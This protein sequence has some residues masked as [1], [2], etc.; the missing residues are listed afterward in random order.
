M[1]RNKDKLIV[2]GIAYYN[3]ICPSIYDNS[4][5]T[6]YSSYEF[7]NGINA[8]EY[9]SIVLLDVKDNREHVI[10]KTLYNVIRHVIR[11]HYK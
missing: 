6:T 2:F 10:N 8:F 1:K 7:V 9:P 4:C 11:T 3:P 5:E